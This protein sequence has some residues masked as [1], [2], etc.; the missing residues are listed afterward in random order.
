MAELQF[1]VLIALLFF[2]TGYIED[3][4]FQRRMKQISL[5]V[6]S[7]ED[8]IV[9]IQTPKKST[10]NEVNEI[11]KVCFAR[12]SISRGIL[13]CTLYE[14]TI[15]FGLVRRNASGQSST[16]RGAFAEREQDASKQGGGTG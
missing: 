6:Q 8:R 13:L 14:P 4:D 5:E 10:E 7:L 3:E 2:L 11:I 12:R 9:E 16:S 15:S 1:V